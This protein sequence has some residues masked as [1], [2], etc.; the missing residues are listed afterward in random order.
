MLWDDIAAQW[1]EFY[2]GKSPYR[3]Y[4][5]SIHSDYTGNNAEFKQFFLATNVDSTPATWPVTGTNWANAPLVVDT[6]VNRLFTRSNSNLIMRATGEDKTVLKALGSTW[7]IGGATPTTS[8]SSEVFIDTTINTPNPLVTDL[9]TFSIIFRVPTMDASRN[10]VLF[11]TDG[12][13]ILLQTDAVGAAVNLRPRGNQ[14]TA[15]TV[16]G[17]TI[18]YNNDYHLLC[19]ADYGSNPTTMLW[20]LYDLTDPTN[21][22]YPQT[23]S[24]V[25]MEV[26]QVLQTTHFGYVPLE[27]DTSPTSNPNMPYCG[28]TLVVPSKSTATRTALINYQSAIY[29]GT[30][31]IPAVTGVAADFFIELDIKQDL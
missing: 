15:P 13:H 5:L 9:S 4:S 1:Y 20:Y 26:F 19:E 28:S 21:F 31:T 8:R 29:N 10:Q 16:T 3:R 18:D 27:P 24:T 23:A 25:A 30:N 7:A 22:L 17:L 2:P 12:Y 11:K 14:T 6:Q